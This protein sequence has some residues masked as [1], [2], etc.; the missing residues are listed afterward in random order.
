[1]WIEVLALLYF[2]RNYTQKLPVVAQVWNSSTWESEVQGHLQPC[3]EFK[4]SLGQEVPSHKTKEWR[5]LG[6]TTQ[7][8]GHQKEARHETHPKT[9]LRN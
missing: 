9:E 6:R 5:G 3:S 2:I 1:M 8:C 4:A 7:E